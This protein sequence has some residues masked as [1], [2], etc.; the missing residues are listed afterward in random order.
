MN[1]ATSYRTALRRL[2]PGLLCGT[3]SL[4]TA[5]AAVAD[6]DRD[7]AQ[8]PAG[9]QPSLQLSP[10]ALEPDSAGIGRRIPRI[11]VIDLDGHRRTLFDHPRDTGTVVIVRDPD[12]PVSKRYGPRISR[13][14]REYGD[15]GYH[16]VFVYPSAVLT[17]SQRLED[18]ERLQVSGTFIEQGSFALAANLGVRSTGDVFV[19]DGEHRLRY[20]GAIDDQYGIG[21]TRDFPTRQYLRNALDALGRGEGVPV[22]ATAAP[23]CYID[24]DPRFDRFLAPLPGGQMLS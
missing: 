6:R 8:P 16:F 21:Y 9:R 11:P 1:R 3:L 12:C 7:A 23:G 15:Q 20:R 24:A 5:M 22:S 19:M 2:I 13:L 17:H 10:Q 18:R 4:G 14:A